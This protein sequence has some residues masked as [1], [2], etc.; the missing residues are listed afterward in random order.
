MPLLFVFAVLGLLA[1]EQGVA[2]LPLFM[3]YEALFGDQSEELLAAKQSDKSTDKPFDK[4]RKSTGLVALLK[5]K[6]STQFGGYH[7]LI[8]ATFA[9]SYNGKL[10]T[11]LICILFVRC[12]LLHDLPKFSRF[13]NPIDSLPSPFK[14]LNYLFIW[15]F[16]MHQFLN[17]TR[18]ACDWSAQSIQLITSASNLVTLTLISASGLIYIVHQAVLLNNFKFLFVSSSLFA[19]SLKEVTS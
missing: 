13:D 3:V 16:N 19:F 11:A 10:F 9:S 7:R 2:V 1:K 14:Q 8:R 12:R 18:L 4:S 15:L 17:P 5:L 6:L